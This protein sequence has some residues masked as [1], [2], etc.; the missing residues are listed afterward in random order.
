MRGQSL[1]ILPVALLLSP[2]A[3][4]GDTR[5]PEAASRADQA[6]VRAL[7]AQKVDVN[8]PLADGTTALH[9]AA[10]NDDEE[11]LVGSSKPAP[12]PGP[13]IITASPRSIT[14]A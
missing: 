8:T 5:L 12:M 4:A 9:W 11:M 1:Y 14:L 10:E 3:F 2:A 7:L 13:A 6:A